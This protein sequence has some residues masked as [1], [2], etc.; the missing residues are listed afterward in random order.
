MNNGVDTESKGDKRSG[1]WLADGK[2]YFSGHLERKFYF[3]LTM[4]LLL[5]GIGYRILGW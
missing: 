2:L 4:A 3:A 5:A 1:L